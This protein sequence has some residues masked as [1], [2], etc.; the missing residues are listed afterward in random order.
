[1]S[2]FDWNKDEK[3]DYRDDA[4]YHNVI[5]KEEHSTKS[6][7]N[8]KSFNQ[9]HESS[10]VGGGGVLFLVLLLFYVLTKIL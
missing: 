9:S 7:D 8:G 4:F 3:K 6:Q 2:H 1:M 10:G 5:N